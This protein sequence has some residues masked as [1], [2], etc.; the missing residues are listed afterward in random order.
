MTVDFAGVE[1]HNP[2]AIVLRL[3]GVEVGRK[4][5]DGSSPAVWSAAVFSFDEV[6]F[7]CERGEYSFQAPNGGP[8]HGTGGD[9]DIP[10]VPG[11]FTSTIPLVPK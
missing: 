8:I 2:L 11:P 9:L 4:P 7:E 5:Y 3:G 10:G 6:V 1:I